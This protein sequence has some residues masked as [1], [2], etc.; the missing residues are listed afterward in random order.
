MVVSSNSS[1]RIVRK[2]EEDLLV[3]ILDDKNLDKSIDIFVQLYNNRSR[4]DQ[5]AWF[6]DISPL[7]SVNEARSK[8]ASL[9]LDLDDDLHWFIS[10]ENGILVKLWE[11][12]RILDY[13]PMTI[14]SIG[15]WTSDQGLILS[16]EEKWQRRRDMQ[17]M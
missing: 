6:L 8:L 5:E 1:D 14:N 15:N 11:V 12:Y 2:K 17:V 9:N 13:R 7:R 4:S 16:K 3:F 10:D